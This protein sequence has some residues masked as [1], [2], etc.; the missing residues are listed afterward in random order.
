MTY[1]QQ[2]FYGQQNYNQNNQKAEQFQ[3]KPREQP[4]M[5]NNQEKLIK[6]TVE[7]DIVDEQYH[8]SI[9]PEVIQYILSHTNE[10]ISA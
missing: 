6:K 7:T 5:Y 4:Q 3:Q 9:K 8:N 10:N 2:G 1:G